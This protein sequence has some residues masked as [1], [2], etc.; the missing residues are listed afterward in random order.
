[1]KSVNFSSSIFDDYNSDSDTVSNNYKDKTKEQ[2]LLVNKK[3]LLKLESEIAQK[4][5][6][7][8][9]DH[10]TTDPEFR[11]IFNIKPRFLNKAR[12]I[13]KT[14]FIK[15][16][17]EVFSEDKTLLN[18]IVYDCLKQGIFK[19]YNKLLTALLL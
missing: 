19:K 1:M 10:L 8:F 4:M 18:Q 9:C 13:I 12:S 6:E 5:A 17:T 15:N 2:K 7:E 3:G 16:A 14:L 11:L